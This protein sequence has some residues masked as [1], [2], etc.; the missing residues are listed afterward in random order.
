MEEEVIM[1]KFIEEAFISKG[2]EQRYEQSSLKVKVE[3][4]PEPSLA[5]SLQRKYIITAKVEQVGYINDREPF[6]EHILPN[7]RRRLYREIYEDIWE[8]LML[9]ERYLHERDFD[10]IKH[11]LDLVIKEV[12]C[13]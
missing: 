5:Y 1:S 8:N 10:G 7:F 12:Q 3:D 9:V 11:H 13:G 4:I 2:Y 6:G